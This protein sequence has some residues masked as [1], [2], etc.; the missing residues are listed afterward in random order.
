MNTITHTDINETPKLTLFGVIAKTYNNLCENAKALTGDITCNIKGNMESVKTYI[1]REIANE[2]ERKFLMEKANK[3]SESIQEITKDVKETVSTLKKRAYAPTDPRESLHAL[4]VL[5]EKI[6]NIINNILV[7]PSIDE[8]VVPS[9]D[10]ETMKNLL[11]F[12]ANIDEN[13]L[14]NLIELIFNLYNKT[15]LGNKDN[16]ISISNT[17][18][19]LF[20]GYLFCEPLPKNIDGKNLEESPIPYNILFATKDMSDK[21]IDEEFNR[22]CKFEKEANIEDKEQPIATTVFERVPLEEGVFAVQPAK[23][24]KRE[25]GKKSNKRYT[26]NKKNKPRK[27]KKNKRSL[28]KKAHKKK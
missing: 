5:E 22:I 27:T 18:K 7:E 15:V 23:K 11:K 1:N 25:G 14:N 17:Q 21:E 16:G 9:I 2:D 6:T 19:L 12:D 10:V 24:Q 28:K 13:K 8:D 4:Y 20:I 3:Y 26:K